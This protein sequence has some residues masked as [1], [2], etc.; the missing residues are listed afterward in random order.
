N[1]WPCTGVTGSNGDVGSLS[2]SSQAAATLSAP[3][4]GTYAGILFFSNRNDTSKVPD[5]K[6]NGGA[7][8]TM[9]GSIYL[10]NSTLAYTGSS[11]SSGYLILVANKIGFTGSSTLTLTNLPSDFSTNN[12]AFKKWA[13]MAE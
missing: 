6:I 2:I 3:T 9:N 13:A 7:R 4:S 8:F 1:G 5:S 11:D 10:P 12:P